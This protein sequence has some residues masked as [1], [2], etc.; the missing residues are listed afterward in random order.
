LP[1]IPRELH[2]LVSD[3]RDAGERAFEVPLQGIAHGVELDPDPV[4]AGPTG[5]A[6]RARQRHGRESG[7]GKREERPPVHSS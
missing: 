4:E 5:A 7:G 1:H 2:F 3:A 6:E